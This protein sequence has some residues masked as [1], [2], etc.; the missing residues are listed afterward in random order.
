MYDVK[1]RV[2]FGCVEMSIQEW[3]EKA[4]EICLQ[5]NVSEEDR[6]YYKGIL[7]S[8]CW[9]AYGRHISDPRDRV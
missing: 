2:F 5:H 4:D 9:A 8:V 7:E 6:A 1:I 3:E